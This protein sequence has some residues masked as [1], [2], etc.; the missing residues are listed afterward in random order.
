MRG[1]ARGP[2]PPRDH[3]GDVPSRGPT[4]AT[5]RHFPLWEKKGVCGPLILA[6]TEY[7]V[8]LCFSYL[9]FKYQDECSFV[10]L[11]LRFP[12]VYFISIIFKFL[13]SLF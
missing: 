7:E 4:Q 2:R 12:F 11:Q 9:E 13:K 3:P 8:F 5:C 6:F 10:R 1:C